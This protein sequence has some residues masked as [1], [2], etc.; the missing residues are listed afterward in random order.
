MILEIN[1]E[2]PQPRRISSAVEV[3]RRG[4]LIAYPTD[5]VYA[6]GGALSQASAVKAME[7]WKARSGSSTPPS[8]LAADVRAISALAVVEDDVFRLIRRLTPGP[9]TFILPASRNVPRKILSRKG[10]HVGVRIPDSA[11][12]Q[13]LVEALGE[14]LITASAKSLSGELLDSPRDVESALRGFSELVLDAGPIHPEPSTV[15]DMTGD[16]PT[17]VRQGKGSIEG[18]GLEVGV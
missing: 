6:I 15:I 16:Y 8:I 2:H 18:L 17:L 12:V 13:A 3:L 5:T 14:P 1:A 7:R 11:V 4:G 9:Y 10:K